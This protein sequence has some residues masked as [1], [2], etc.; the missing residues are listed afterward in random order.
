[1]FDDDIRSYLTDE[2]RQEI[3]EEFFAKGVEAGEAKTKVEMAKALKELGD[4][5]DKIARV[6]GLSPEEISAL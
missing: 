1:M 3:A 5:D 4:P 6:S 2:D